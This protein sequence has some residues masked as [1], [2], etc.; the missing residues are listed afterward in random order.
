[1]GTTRTNYGTT[2]TTVPTTAETAAVVSDPVSPS[3]DG[4]EITISGV[5]NITTGASTTSSISVTT[6]T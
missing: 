6:D 1:M 3:T 4:A 2:D 5:V